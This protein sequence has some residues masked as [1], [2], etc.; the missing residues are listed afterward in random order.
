MIKHFHHEL[1]RLK[2]ELFTL[3]AMV[4]EALHLSVRAV[5][6]RKE[7]Y[8]SQV[9]KNDELIDS[10]EVD[11]EEECLKIL[12][13][14]QPVAG[15]LRYIIVVLKM[16]NDLERIG[17][18]AVNIAHRALSLMKLPK[19]AALFDFSEMAK[20]VEEMLKQAL[21][22]LV[23]FDASLAESVCR[24]DDAVDELNRQMH[25]RIRSEIRANIDDVES[26][27]YYMSV[28]R[29]LE[30]I[31]DHTTNIAEDVVYLI[32]GHIIRHGRH[33]SAG[34]TSKN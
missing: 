27:T 29:N 21:E 19:P 6:E 11:I 5:M 4:E 3:S 24:S 31:A 15:D 1:V 16:N 23:N 18:L 10:K 32:E 33:V 14:Y 26:L 34:E 25:N 12:A 17:D 2:K 28:S 22:S 8:A 30:R 13:L 9:I 7:E 20:K